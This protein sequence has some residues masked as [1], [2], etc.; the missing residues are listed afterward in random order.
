MAVG[1]PAPLVRCRAAAPP[2]AP[3]PAIRASSGAARSRVRV[4]PGATAA[5]RRAE[6]QAPCRG[7]LLE[8]RTCFVEQQWVR[9]YEVEADQRISVTSMC[10]LLQECATNH[11]VNLWGKNDDLG[12][13]I[14][15]IMVEK[16]LILV[17]TRQQL[18]FERYPKWGDLVEVET[19][20]QQEGRLAAR[21]DWAVRDGKTKET[22]GGGSSTWV[23]VNMKTRKLSKI[24][25]EMLEEFLPFA[26]DPPRFGLGDTVCKLRLPELELPAEFQA[27]PQ[28][29]RKT[30]IDLNGHMNNVT[31]ISLALE[32]VPEDISDNM[33]IWQVE[34]DFKGE[35]MAGDTIECLASSTPIP[36]QSLSPEGARAV[37]HVVRKCNGEDCKEL[38]RMRS[39]W[40]PKDS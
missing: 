18:Q 26:P 27:P 35:A 40:R 34:V 21:R 6:L 32:A 1:R 19:W 30:D 28:V 33:Q 14:A 20:Y 17:M 5:D 9:G 31:Y 2:A 3:A 4:V 23:M 16:N 11:A 38:V 24:P 8:G 29:A 36:E 15:P 10:N 13:A 7:E 25:D 22:I 12:F 37:L 39:I